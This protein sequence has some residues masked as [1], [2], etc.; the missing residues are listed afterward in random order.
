MWFRE[1]RRGFF[2]PVRK[3][4]AR[5]F[6]TR[7]DTEL[8]T[9]LLA[10]QSRAIDSF[11]QRVSQVFQR[12]NE[13]SQDV[14]ESSQRLNEISQDVNE[15]SQR[16]N[17]VMR[18]IETLDQQLGG[19]DRRIGL[20]VEHLTARLGDI[21]ASVVRI[22]R[23]AKA[24]MGDRSALGHAIA[25][26]ETAEQFD[27]Q[28]IHDIASRLFGGAENVKDGGSSVG[29]VV[30]SCDRPDGLRRALESIAA[31]SRK[32]SVV[33][34]V[35]DGCADITSVLEEFS[36]E[37]TISALT[38]DAPYSGSS[39]A[40]NLALGVLNTELVAFLDDDNLMWPRWIERAAAFLEVDTRMD[41]LYGA[42]LRDAELSTTGKNWFFVPFDFETLKMGNFIDLNQVMHRSSHVRFD[43]NLRRLV[44]WD[45]LLRLIG[46]SPERTVPVD[47]ISS[48]YSTSDLDRISVAYWP[49]DLGQDI[50]RRESTLK[51]FSHDSHACSC[52]GF[53]G[54]FGPG[55]RQRPYASCP[56]CGS[57]ERHRFLQLIGPLLRDFW[58][59]QTRPPARATMIEVAPSGATAPFRNLF[60]IST[61]IDAD[62][63]ADGRTVD[64][65]ASLS[66]LPM[67]SEYA[68]VV[69]ALHVLEHIADDRRA[70]S[71]IARVLAP[72]GL[73]ILQVP[74]S[75][76]DTTEEEVL[77]TPEER[78]V[79]YGQA[80][81]V[82]LYEKDFYQRLSDS[83]LTSIAVSPR[84]SMVPATVAKYGLLPDEPLVFAVRSDVLRAKGRLDV[85][86]SSLRKGS[87]LVRVN[88]HRAAP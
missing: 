71:E 2:S 24:A 82:R 8:L 30:P 48:L 73:A 83:G 79:R 77:E 65:V 54:E 14:N 78:S 76:R 18:R 20:H 62:P 27:R 43:P 58:L 61:T 19:T 15:S 32:P 6:A 53:V 74:M 3:R 44:D 28:A 56:Q 45:Y 38:T 68:D 80:D 64:L 11:S 39:V 49:P 35:N 46:S 40:R 47:A 50:A 55:P 25:Q 81:H 63:E 84:E 22:E 51:V 10:E 9:G 85:F 36:G 60:G 21:N 34:V 41:I 31:Q 59:P 12:F 52:C 23:D 26:L 67:A 1:L 72:T 88:N 42:Q 16:L 87:A 37:L 70:M 13:I 57:L 29:V 66:D 69:L 17:E 33:M 7:S 86:A 5:T 75:G 4:L